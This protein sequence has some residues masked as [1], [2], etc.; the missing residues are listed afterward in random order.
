[1]KRYHL[2]LILVLGFAMNSIAQPGNDL[3][4]EEV[5]IEKQFEA[6][7]REANKKPTSP[8]LPP[9]DTSQ[10]KFQFY[11][12]PPRLLTL[13][14]DA[15]VIRPIAMRKAPEEPV[16]Q[17]YS[18][19]GYGWPSSPF[20][21]VRFHNGKSDK[22]SFNAD[23]LHH[24]L[25][26]NKQRENMRFGNTSGG[27]GGEY[28]LD[29]TYA[30]GADLGFRLDQHHF[31]GYQASDTSRA[32]KDV[33]QQFLGLNGGLDF[34]NVKK[35]D[36]DFNYHAGLDFHWVKD[37]FDSRETGFGGEIGMNKWFN[38]HQ[39]V[40][41]LKDYVR[42]LNADTTSQS[43]NLLE[44]EPAFHIGFGPARLKV[45]AYIGYDGEFSPFPDIEFLVNLMDGKVQFFG[46]WNG[47]IEQKSFDQ[48][49]KINPYLISN[50]ELRNTRVQYRYGGVKGQFNKFAYEVRGGHRPTKDLGLFVNNYAEDSTR[51][52]L[53]YDEVSTINIHTTLNVNP[54]KDLAIV[55]SGDYNI[56]NAK[57]QAKAWH[58]PALEAN[59]GVQ[60]TFK[61]KL[62]LKAET[63]MA[64]AV[65]YLT[66]T[67]T[68]DQLN[69]LFDI[70]FG[71]SYRIHEKFSLFL[72][73]NNLASSK[74]QRY[75]NYPTVGF[76]V[77]GG[78]ILK[79]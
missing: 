21:D 7:V 55:L 2:I 67:G 75:Y 45:G 33:A 26:A 59:L 19:I 28:Y 6:A 70:N 53:I 20:A 61:E 17:F 62:K 34:R 39:L 22:F 23:V 38:K 30:F 11:D 51:F 43:N 42:T 44:F 56:F 46:G 16:H 58:L 74:Y 27:I 65:N 68:A 40:I 29:E 14:Y 76:N 63:Y 60:Y 78:I 41:S 47:S 69:N 73:L 3:P 35:T 12:I 54:I 18:K 8:N 9:V 13:E 72:D 52:G 66:S 37:K 1:M 4:S 64:S 48:L 50:P 10:K 36:N 15:P 5:N 32:R 77:L 71:A 31:Y 49:S 79:F 25:N 57:N 24:S